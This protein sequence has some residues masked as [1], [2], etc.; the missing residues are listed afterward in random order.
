ML[1]N[2]SF[3]YILKQMLNIQMHTMWPTSFKTAEGSRT[4]PA[5]EIN[6]RIVQKRKI[7]LQIISKRTMNTTYVFRTELQWN[8]CHTGSDK[9]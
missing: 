2:T 5:F 8:I 4:L 6:R 1:I 7:W 9:G 3:L